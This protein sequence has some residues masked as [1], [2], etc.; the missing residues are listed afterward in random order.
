MSDKYSLI[1]LHDSSQKVRRFR[2]SARVIKFGLFFL[3]FLVL[4][5]SGGVVLS[6]HT[7]DQFS[8]W[9]KE[10]SE[11]KTS[12]AEANMQLERLQNVEIFLKD[13]EKVA[14]SQAPLDKGSAKEDIPSEKT[15]KINTKEV[16]AT[17]FSDTVKALAKNNAEITPA[18]ETDSTLVSSSF[19]NKPVGTTSPAKISNVDISARSPKSVSL[20]FDLNNETPGV[21]LSGDVQLSLVT[22][23]DQVHAIV[24]P[25]S[26]MIFQINYY[27]RINTAFPLPQGIALADIKALT[28][29]VTAN[30]KKLQTDTILF[31]KLD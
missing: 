19:A 5:I 25:R 16:L 13:S 29:T 9:S 30:G 6:F 14:L 22:K 21:T 1:I 12:L 8:S 26:D 2:I 20:A 3:L 17:V 23:K 28:L 18:E 10:N 27:K 15:A 7:F 31:P 4:L 11:L 24:V